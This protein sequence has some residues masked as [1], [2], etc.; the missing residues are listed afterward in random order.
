MTPPLPPLNAPDPD[1]LLG[2]EFDRVSHFTV[3]AHHDDL[4]FNTFSAIEASRRHEGVTFGGVVCTDGRGSARSGAYAGMTDDELAASRVAEQ[5]KA[6]LIGSY[7]AL[8][9]LGFPSATI[10]Q[11]AGRALLISDLAA[12]FRR[13][14]PEVVYIHNLADKHPTHLAV[15][16]ASLAALRT[17]APGE[18][19]LRLLGY[20][21]WRSLDWLPDDRKVV[22]DA[23]ADAAFAGD[24]YSVFET[25]IGGGKRY[26]RAV[27]GR[28]FANATFLNPHAVD[29]VEMAELAVDLT[30]LIRDD[31][32]DPAEFML[33]LIGE[34]RD[35]VASGLK[36]FF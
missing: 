8:F 27:L 18:R 34:F 32:F 23:G 2:T 4:E 36:E 25:Q 24:L 16:A 5:R 20:E 26:D 11:P 21:A 10:R 29:A 30:P 9:Q 15:A 14:R 1:I 33:D 17:M 28:K 22:L 31:S 7:S 12:I 19:P 35:Q 13:V 3:G 6:A